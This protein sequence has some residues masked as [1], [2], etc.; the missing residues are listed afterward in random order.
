MEGTEIDA[1]E[2]R[3][4]EPMEISKET[5]KPPKKTAEK[6]PNIEEVKLGKKF[7]EFDHPLEGYDGEKRS[8]VEMVIP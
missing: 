7:F 2:E 5:D 1:E 4:D 8:G 6:N 3:H